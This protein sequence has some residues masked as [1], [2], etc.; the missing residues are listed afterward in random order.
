MIFVATVK[1][2]LILIVKCDI[3]FCGVLCFQRFAPIRLAFSVER[4]FLSCGNLQTVLFVLCPSFPVCEFLR[5]TATSQRRMTCKTKVIK[6]APYNQQDAFTIPKPLLD[7]LKRTL[8]NSSSNVMHI[9]APRL[10]PCPIKHH[11]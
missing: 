7:I 6:K 10:K 4:I 3:I 9:L 8:S 2:S 5:G 11:V 1:N